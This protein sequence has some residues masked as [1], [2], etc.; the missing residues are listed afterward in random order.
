MTDAQTD[1]DRDRD[2]DHATCDIC[3]NRPHSICTACRR[4]GLKPIISED[5]AQ[6]IVRGVSP[7]GRRES[8]AEGFVKQV[9]YFSLF[10]REWKS[11][12]VMDD[13]S[14]ESAVDWLWVCDL[15]NSLIQTVKITH[16]IIV[17]IYRYKH[18][19]TACCKILELHR[20]EI[21]VAEMTSSF[22]RGQPGAVREGAFLLNW[23]R[24]LANWTKCMRHYW[25]WPNLDV[26]CF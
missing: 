19:L 11:N 14:V 21:H 17:F 16:I 15:E 6:V 10:Y 7:E 2:T 9:G 5:T 18:L 3:S 13:D 8:T 26:L 1:R 4:C 25:F 20:S 24:H 12:E 22:T 23:C